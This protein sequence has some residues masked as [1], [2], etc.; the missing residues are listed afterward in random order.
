MAGHVE[1]RLERPQP[2]V[3]VILLAQLLACQFVQD[4]HFLGQDFGGQ[5]AGAEQFDLTDQLV[6]RDYAHHGPEQRFHGFWK[7]RSTRV[8]RIHR[9]EYADF[10]VERYI[11]ALELTH[12]FREI[13]DTIFLS[14]TLLLNFCLDLP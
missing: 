11:H 13:L 6:I 8:S 1:H 12:I 5:E 3:V 4:C 9:D 10:R 2:E 7:F 14:S